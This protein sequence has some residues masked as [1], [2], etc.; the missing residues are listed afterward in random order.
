MRR[1]DF[2][3]GIAGTAAAWPLA[4]RAQ[5]PDRVPPTLIARADEVIE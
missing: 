3:S 4:A 2:I 1:R 5:Q